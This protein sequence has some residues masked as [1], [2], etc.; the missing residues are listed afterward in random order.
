MVTESAGDRPTALIVTRNFPPLTGGMERLL[1]QTAKALS[2]SF[3]VTVI[4]PAGSRRYFPEGTVIE[5][6][7][8][9][10]FFL[11]FATIKGVF[12]SRRRRYSF[13][14]AGSGLTAPIAVWLSKLRRA[15]SVVYVHGLDLVV[16]SA[17][18]QRFFVP[19]IVRSDITIANSRNTR[20]IALTKGCSEQQLRVLNP[21]TDLPIRIGREKRAALRSTY[22]AGP[23]CLFVGRITPR[24]G[25]STFI[26]KT[27]TQVIDERP[28][29]RLIV[30]G[31]SPEN[32]VAGKN[33]EIDAVRLAVVESK[34]ASSIEFLG[35]VDDDLLDDYYSL[36]DVLIFPLV[37]IDGDVEGFGM[38]AIEAAARGTPT[39]AF[40]EGGVTD[41]V[42]DPVSGRLIPPGDYERF[43]QAIHAVAADSAIRDRCREHAESFG[44]EHYAV[45][46]LDILRPSID[47]EPKSTGGRP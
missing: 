26:R 31:D 44:W 32:A 5:C 7:A 15:R 45:R 22:G 9:P 8:S 29:A 18:Y 17:L 21:G 10:I 3:D 37:P 35:A 6:P 20:K 12:H 25:L 33:D 40:S 19:W 38:V 27:W 47:A 11:L 39:I 34:S 46:L 4:G 24:K 36:A 1:H 23:I 41:A 28:G 42:D 16:D 13:V 30:I 43:S 2:Q 14:L